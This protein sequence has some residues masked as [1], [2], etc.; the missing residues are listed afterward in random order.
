MMNFGNNFS[1]T[2]VKK[3]EDDDDEVSLKTVP[4]LPNTFCKFI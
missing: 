3:Y 4:R 2:P 1:Q